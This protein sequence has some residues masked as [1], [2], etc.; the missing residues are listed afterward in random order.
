MLKKR[1]KETK[2][3]SE[4][5]KDDKKMQNRV[6][7]SKE[8]V[9]QLF[10]DSYIKKSGL[11]PKDEKVLSLVSDL[12]DR[13]L[14]NSKRLGKT[15]KQKIGYREKFEIASKKTVVKKEEEEDEE[16]E[17]DDDDEEKKTKNE[18]S[19]FEKFRSI[20]RDKATKVVIN[21]IIKDHKDEGLSFDDVYDKIREVY[22][23]KDTDTSRSDFEKRIRLAYRNA[24]PALYEEDVKSKITK[25]ANEEEDDDPKHKEFKEKKKDPARKNRRSNIKD[26]YKGDK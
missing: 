8:E 23:E 1:K 10:M 19:G 14:S 16:E 6:G 18:G 7:R 9:K 26:W 5:I 21:K 17:D 12:A 13:E 11:D 24:F 3:S 2:V 25:E 4:E 15:L 20:E 22:V